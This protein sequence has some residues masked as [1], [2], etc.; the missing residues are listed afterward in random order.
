[1]VVDRMWESASC[2]MRVGWS[3]MYSTLCCTSLNVTG[4]SKLY[5]YFELITFNL[6]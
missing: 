6:K 1:V 4:V 3:S 2:I 5:E